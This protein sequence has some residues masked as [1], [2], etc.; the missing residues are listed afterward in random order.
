M[1][2]PHQEDASQQ[3]PLDL[4]PLFSKFLGTTDGVD[5]VADTMNS[6]EGQFK[7]L[8]KQAQPDVQQLNAML[9]SK[10]HSFLSTERGKALSSGLEKEMS[11]GTLAVPVFLIERLIKQRLQSM[12]QQN[13]QRLI[14][15]FCWRTLFGTLAVQATKSGLRA[16][17]RRFFGHR[18]RVVAVV[19]FTTEL[20]LSTGFLGPAL[21]ITV[22]MMELSG[23]LH[24]PGVRYGNGPA[25]SAAAEAATASV[26]VQGVSAAG[27]AVAQAVAVIAPGIGAVAGQAAE[28][29]QE[30]LSDLAGTKH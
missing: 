15:F 25:A 22:G 20:L 18:P 12:A 21:G 1:A 6:I 16:L 2:T 14:F 29:L 24:I 27:T 19:D 10:F 30:Q 5:F 8:R 17:T 7:R 23:S 4:S 11:D 9:M 3:M 13:V 26:A 28:A